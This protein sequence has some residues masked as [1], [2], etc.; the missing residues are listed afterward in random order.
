M[1][2]IRRTIFNNFAL[3]MLALLV[4]APLFAAPQTPD[5][6]KKEQ[7]LIENTQKVADGSLALNGVT[8]DT[9][10]IATWEFVRDHALKFWDWLS[11]RVHN[12]LYDDFLVDQF[13]PIA[14]LVLIV[15]LSVM[16]LSGCWAASIAQSRRHP[17]M[18]FFFLGFFTFFIGPAHLLFNLDIKGEKEMLE[19]LAQEA[20][21]KRAEKEARE[22]REQA[23]LADKGKVEAPAVSENGVVWDEKYFS[24][25][26][27]KADGTPDGPWE[28]TYNGIHVRVLE[29]LEVLP[30]LVAVRLV[31]PE[32]AELKGRIPYA[33]ITQWDRALPS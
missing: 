20:A 5:E 33:K 3:A 23:A 28:V 8:N 30:A 10:L 18:P 12:V 11:T 22:Q 19:R 6:I 26:Q 21:A 15:V 13:S 4:V 14:L 16:F 2:R 27:R 17:R 24:S 7:E 9:W 1:K 32:G 31:N 25:I 29:I